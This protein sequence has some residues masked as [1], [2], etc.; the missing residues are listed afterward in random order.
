M[1]K[2]IAGVFIF[3]LLL[4]SLSSKHARAYEQTVPICY[5]Q[6]A[7]YKF[8]W[9]GDSCWD[10]FEMSCSVGKVAFAS[11]VIKMLKVAKDTGYG[12]PAAAMETV[13]KA[14]MCAAV[15]DECVAPKLEACKSVCQNEENRLFYAPDLVA[16]HNW[17]GTSGVGY[18]NG[19]LYFRI[20]N[21]GR[22]YASDI[23]IKAEWGHTAERDGEIDNYQLLFEDTADEL[24]FMGSRQSS[25]KGATDIV[26]DF[27][28]DESNFTNFLSKYK[29]DY[30]QEFIPPV[31][32]KEIDFTPPAD[33]LTKIKLTVDPE[34]IIPETDEEDNIFIY[35]IDNRPTPAQFQITEADLELTGDDLTKRNLTATIKNNGE[36]GGEAT[37]EIYTK[38]HGTYGK[39][40]AQ[41]TRY[42]E[43]KETITYE[44]TIPITFDDD[45]CISN[46]TYFI[47]VTDP[48]EGAYRR[49]MYTTGYLANVHGYV[50]NSSGEAVEGAIVKVSSGQ[51]ATTNERGYYMIKGIK[52]LGNLTVT[53]RHP[54]YNVQKTEEVNVYIDEPENTLCSDEGLSKKVN[55]TLENEPAEV[56]FNITDKEGT[57]VDNAQI[58][59][60]NDNVRKNTKKKTINAEI[61]TYTTRITAP[62]YVPHDK[63]IELASGPQTLEIKLKRFTAR[64]SDQGFKL[65]KPN[66]LWE[67]D[68]KL[69]GRHYIER[70]AV[71]KDGNLLVIYTVDTG[72]KNSGELH[73]INTETGETI[74]TVD[75]PNSKG[76]PDM[77]IDI[78]WDGN[79][80]AYYTS[81]SAEY[82]RDPNRRTLLKLFDGTGNEIL[83]KDFEPGAATCAD[84]SPDGYYLHPDRLMNRSGYVY[85]RWDTQGI[86]KST[87]EQ[88]FRPHGVVHFLTDNTIIGACKESS[89]DD[90]CR[91]DIYENVLETFSNVKNVRSLDSSTDGKTVAIQTTDEVL[92]FRNGSLTWEK[93]VE[94]GNGP[95][96][97]SV[98]PGGEYTAVMNTSHTTKEDALKLFNSGGENLVKDHDFTYTKY[99]TAN[100]KGI[101]YI[102]Q[103]NQEGRGKIEYYQIAKFPEMQETEEKSPE[104]EPPSPA[105]KAAAAAGVASAT[106]VGIFLAKKQG[107]DII[108]IL[109]NAFLGGGE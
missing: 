36:E 57:A 62:G 85:T 67:K 64:D 10:F 1:K 104:G 84:L 94:R 76:N 70:Y 75:V 22:G 63:E 14:L 86:E 8:Y 51:T 45:Y 74:K 42:F 6:C 55:F 80:V 18:Y 92:L 58:M 38:E 29:S 13:A 100:E 12:N 107:I 37:I 82:S 87:L 98:T 90:Y 53:A 5:S 96:L 106:G 32:L 78:S 16:D 15:A 60:I 52:Q 47:K 59:L 79:T 4:S 97:V 21:T 49:A 109:K 68:F 40:I 81:I 105:K 69:N 89:Y 2:G 17:Y 20:T 50:E 19:K 46:K 66:L 56:T 108:G 43:G 3:F 31:W 35:E 11:K 33:E 34:N 95:Y 83:S 41:E 28:I 39:L 48:Y 71:S 93:E 102:K 44:T 7:A 91:T 99:A 72:T 30:G 103:P 9:N 73:F 65:L 27:L 23:A 24:L 88:S 61:G 77:A 101:F 26:K 25:P 54:D